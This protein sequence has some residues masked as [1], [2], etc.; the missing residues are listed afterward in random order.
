LFRPAPNRTKN[1]NSR[2][3]L[4]RETLSFRELLQKGTAALLVAVGV[5]LVAR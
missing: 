2:Q 5:A 1:A 3:R 4:A